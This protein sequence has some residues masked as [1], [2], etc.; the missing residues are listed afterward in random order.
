[1][2]PF[3]IF[4]AFN[5]HADKYVTSIGFGKYMHITHLVISRHFFMYNVIFL[6]VHILS[7][8]LYQFMKNQSVL[9]TDIVFELDVA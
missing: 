1:M 5:E 7:L 6:R 4:V 3:V 8:H 2:D 9:L